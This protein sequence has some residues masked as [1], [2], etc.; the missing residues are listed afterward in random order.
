MSQELS[1]SQYLHNAHAHLQRIGGRS[2]GTLAKRIEA[3]DEAVRDLQ[4]TLEELQAANNELRRESEQFGLVH[5][6][7]ETLFHGAPD[8]HVITDRLG[9]IWRANR[10]AALLLQYPLAQLERTPLIHYLSLESR[11]AFL[12]QMPHLDRL[13]PNHEFE[14]SVQPQFG[15]AFP[16]AMTI[17]TVNDVITGQVY[18]YWQIRNVSE[19]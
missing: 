10:A 12:D 11:R 14:Y 4:A 1:Y 9:T 7:F 3:A 2:S 6:R 5:E 15:T 13:A 19:R 8:C 18:L 17:S 16:A